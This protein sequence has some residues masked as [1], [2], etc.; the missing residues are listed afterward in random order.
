MI[1]V[2]RMVSVIVSQ[3]TERDAADF[4]GKKRIFGGVVG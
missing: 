1:E 2:K 3:I 4:Y